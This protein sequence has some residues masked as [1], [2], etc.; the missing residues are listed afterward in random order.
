M[1][2]PEKKFYDLLSPHLP[3]D[4]SRV[5][6]YADTGTPDVSGACGVD[7]WVETKVCTNT[8]KIRPVEDFF[9]GRRATQRVWHK[10]RAAHGTHI[11]VMVRYP[12]LIAVYTVSKDAQYVLENIYRKKGNKWPWKEFEFE[13]KRRVIN[14][15]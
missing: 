14:W 13:I 3:G 2:T 12:E 9:K 4:V 8:Q 6:N 11:F 5:E 1:S 10:R 15:L 7:Y